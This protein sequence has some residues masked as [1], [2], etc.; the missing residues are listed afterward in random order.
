MVLSTEYY[1]FGRII[2]LL[3]HPF[4]L[5]SR[6]QF[7]SLSQSSCRS[8]ALTR[9]WGRGWGRS[10]IIGLRESLALCNSFSTL[11]SEAI[12]TEKIHGEKDII[13][14]VLSMRVFHQFYFKCL[15]KRHLIKFFRN[16]RLDA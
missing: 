7:A 10:Q 5:L 12:F 11:W 15:K 9:E 2:R 14:E 4:P 1:S 3:A 8:S 6:Q 16:R 13:D